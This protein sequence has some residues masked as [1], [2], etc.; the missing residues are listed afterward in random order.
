MT[1]RG[2]EPKS[3]IKISQLVITTEDKA[4]MLSEVSQAISEAD[5]NIEAINAHGLEGK[6]K[7]YIIT[8]ENQKVIPALKTKG[9]QVEEEEVVRIDLENKIG[10]LSQ[11]GA[12][13]KSAGVNLLYCY[14]TVSEGTSPCRF[15]LKA[16]DNDKAIE[17][18]G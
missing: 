11:I 12:K 8:S 18:L 4:G 6:A 16:E 3:G 15:I 10:A 5:V 7:F 17:T 9:W 14:G 13:L 2:P 1:E